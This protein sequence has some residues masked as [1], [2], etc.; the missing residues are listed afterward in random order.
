MVYSKSQKKG[1]WVLYIQTRLKIK[2]WIS[3]HPQKIDKVYYRP[4]YT[5]KL[6]IKIC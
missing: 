1:S 2:I 6:S 4:Y 3:P 5:P